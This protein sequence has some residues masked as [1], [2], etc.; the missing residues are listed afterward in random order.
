MTK[1]AFSPMIGLLLLVIAVIGFM[2]LT[3][4]NAPR[5]V[6]TNVAQVPIS[7][8][9]VPIPT[10]TQ[11]ALLSPTAILPTVE[12]PLQTPPGTQ[13]PVTEQPVTSSTPPFGTTTPATSVP[14]ATSVQPTQAPTFP[15]QATV[16]RPTGIV[17]T[18]LTPEPSN[19]TVPVVWPMPTADP[20]QLAR[21]AIMRNNDALRNLPGVVIAQGTNT[22]PVGNTNMRSYVVE[23]ITLSSPTQI[24]GPTGEIITISVAWRFA[25]TGKVPYVGAQSYYIVLNGYSV[26]CQELPDR[27]VGLVT[28]ASWLQENA[29]IALA[30]GYQPVVTLPERLHFITPPT[31]P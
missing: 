18:V 26:P 8:P 5:A 10:V 27:C 9:S 22:T 13:A 29:T 21:N 14:S 19:S 16:P 11:I 1:R 15:P 2:L 31:V 23:Q 6:D 20:T 3:Q 30:Y 7:S 17:V 12:S 4:A 24:F 28:D 25:I